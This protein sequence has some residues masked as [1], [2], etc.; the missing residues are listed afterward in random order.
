MFVALSQFAVAN[1][2]TDQVKEAF[3]R[4]PQLVD[5]ADGFVKLDVISPHDRPDEIW[6]ITYWTDE[7]SYRTWHRSHLHREA[8]K[9]IPKG[10]KLDA[11]STK[12][13]FFEH[14]CS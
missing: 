8:H 2:M 9:G 1:G 14:I 12:L 13:R 11:K 7:A 10:L 5:G 6:L 4:R 3:R